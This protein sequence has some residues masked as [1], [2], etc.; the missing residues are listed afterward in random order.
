MAF[1]VGIM[2]GTSLDGVDAA[3]V[4]IHGTNTDTTVQLVE[5]TTYPLS[6][7]IV[8]KIKEVLSIETSSVDKICSLNVE[9]GYVFS[10]AAKAVCEKA[11]FP[12]DQV[13]FVASHGQTIY[14]LPV[15][16][17]HQS[18]STL[19]IGESAIIAEETKTMVVSDFRTRDM[20]VNGQGAPIVP[21]SEF[22]LY[23][24]AE[25]TRLLQN[26]GGI[27][28]VTVI[29]SGA[30]MEEV[31]AFDTGP[32]NM[33]IDELCQHFYQEAYDNNGEH[34]S[35]GIVDQGMLSEM[36]AHPY[37][38]RKH[39]KTTGREDFGAEYTA[40]L[41]G[42][43]QNKVAP[44][45]FIA[46]ATQFT[47]Q[48]IAANIRPF[49]NQ[50]TDLIIGG[51]G[52]YNP[53][54]VKMIKEQLPEIT[55]LIQEEVGFSSEAKEAIAMTILANQT[56]HHLP[57]NVPSATGATKPVILGKITYYH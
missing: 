44:D 45:D 39:P 19:Q 48:S 37:I 52:S 2:S 41:I 16:G 10:E 38:E 3:L 26:I 50:Q 8:G 35:K 11:D 33:I 47:V 27:G 28:N 30:Q 31:I 25:R 40:N 32:G 9:L 14:H 7:E 54:L 6:T 18:A 51:G 42:Q 15:P 17:S 4:E 24:D 53:T 5:F 36:M 12:L 13:D 55:V 1:A 46:T 20:A 57:S 22:I 21:Y 43:W 29:P 34:A 23:R 56:I 49:I